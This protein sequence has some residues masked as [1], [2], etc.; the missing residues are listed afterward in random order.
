MFPL[1]DTEP[2]RYSW[3]PFMTI[4][5]IAINT[6]IEIAKPLYLPA[7]MT[8]WQTWQSMM[9]FY[10]RPRYWLRT[11]KKLRSREDLFR[12]FKGLRMALGFVQ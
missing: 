2:N 5:L 10:F 9:R 12:M 6:F 7:N 8:L 4:S 11:V 1:N 3:F